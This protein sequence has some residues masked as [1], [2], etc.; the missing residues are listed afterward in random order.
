[1]LRQF[2]L[3]MDSKVCLNSHVIAHTKNGSRWITDILVKETI[4]FSE[5]NTRGHFCDLGRGKSLEAE[6]KG[7]K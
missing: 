5:E 3:H 4:E 6:P 7:P 2:V 1:M